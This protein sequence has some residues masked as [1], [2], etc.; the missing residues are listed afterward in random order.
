ME[1]VEFYVAPDGDDRSDGSLEAPFATLTRARD[2]VRALRRRGLPS[3]GVTINLRAGTYL[4]DRSLLLSPEDSGAPEAPIVYCAHDGEDVRLVAGRELDADCFTPVDD[5]EILDRI[6]SEDARVKLLQLDLKAHG[7]SDYGRLSRRGFVADEGDVAPTELFICGKRMTLA[8][9]PNEGS[10][11]M[12]EVID[13]GPPWEWGEGEAGEDGWGAGRDNTGFWESGGTFRYEFDRP[14]LWQKADDIWLDGVFSEDWAWSYNRVARID[15]EQKTITLRYGDVYR[16]QKRGD[17]DFFHAENLLEEIDMP[18]EYYIDR[19]TGILYLLPPENF[20]PDARVVI[21]T[22]DVP[23][24]AMDN[25]SRVTFRDLVFEIGRSDAIQIKGGEGVRIE[26]CEIRDFA[27]CGVDINGDRH[28]VVNCHLHHLGAAAVNLRG[29]DLEQL[30]PGGNLVEN[31]YIHHF[32]YLNKVY[33]AGIALGGVAHQ[34]RH[35]LIHDAP[36][37][38]MS[39][40]GND[41]LVEYNE[42]HHATTAFRDMGAIYFCT[43]TSPHHRGTVIRRNYFH[44]TGTEV[45]RGS[46]CGGVYT[47]DETCGVVVE[48]NIFYRLGSKT[49]DWSVM[50]HG[51]SHVH[52]RNNIFVDCACPFTVSYRLNGYAKHLLQGYMRAWQKLFDKYDFA[53]MTHGKKYPELLRFLAEDR[54]AP[55]T[56]TLE[57]NL[58]YNPTRE[59]AI[60]DGWRIHDGV[61][62]E[63]DSPT[64]PDIQH[65]L[66][67]SNNWV[68]EEDPGFVDLDGGN[69]SLRPDAPAFDR[70]PG[71]VDLPFREMGLKSDVSVGPRVGRLSPR[72]QLS[73][74]LRGRR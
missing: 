44:D 4:I 55:D 21:S 36:H 50:V 2:A 34:I 59:R 71:F 16:L 13:P 30:T 58:I 53:N 46:Q 6:I 8:R 70:I 72:R 41:H 29:G 67:Q 1:T 63:D 45:S 28:A 64:Y 74:C 73:R 61:W 49:S 60:E 57:R 68:A 42:F 7:I 23:L 32:A 17:T 9:W 19:S 52:T 31:C 10:V 18:G 54:I 56:N 62:S 27:G 66:R 37:M 48:E 20:S 35:C 33:H 14:E 51:A 12:A 43:G 5:S 47:D 15:V 3:K 11:S 26:N 69:L 25:V 65:R 38:A 40:G 24:V 22:L 39:G